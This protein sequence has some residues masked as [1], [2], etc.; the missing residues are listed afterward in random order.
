MIKIVFLIFIQLSNAN[1]TSKKEI[2]FELEYLITSASQSFSGEEFKT[3]LKKS[4]GRVFHFY[5]ELEKKEF[6]YLFKVSTYKYLL[7]EKPETR[8]P[9]NYYDSIYL[10][11]FIRNKRPA[12]LIGFDQ[13]VW[14]SLVRDIDIIT[15]DPTYFRFVNAKKKN[16]IKSNL[17]ILDKKIR[18]AL[19][20][21]IQL[22]LQ[23][24]EELNIYMREHYLNILEHAALN[25]KIFAILKDKKNAS[26]PSKFDLATFLSIEESTNM[27]KSSDDVKK[28][29]SIVDQVTKEAL[30]KPV[31]D[32]I[33][34][35]DEFL[36]E[37]D[38]N[39]LPIPVDDWLNEF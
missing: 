27:N 13:W 35:S 37:D 22:K 3:K 11:K 12:H 9:V 5:K 4:L 38:S 20:W 30:P 1:W 25:M 28:I 6:Y 31:D 32:W 24:P 34:E 10:N 36:L 15:R 2:P 29:K 21:L 26:F 39:A 16:Q 23:T 7:R 8:I 14:D 17:T 19:P 18:L 33:L